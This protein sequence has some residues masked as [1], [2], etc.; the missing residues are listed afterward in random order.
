M[1]KFIG[2]NLF[3]LYGIIIIFIIDL[4]IPSGTPVAISYLIPLTMSYI[5]SKRTIVINAII[6][7]ALTMIDTMLSYKILMINTTLFHSVAFDRIVAILTIWITCF[8]VFR[9][10]DER[11]KMEAKREKYLNNISD[12]LFKVSHEVRSPL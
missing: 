5:L 3:P 12:I 11:I 7:T 10:K 4:M 8:I 9:F 2:Q 6:A 1:R